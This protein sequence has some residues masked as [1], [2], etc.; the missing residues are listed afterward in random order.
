MTDEQI[1]AVITAGVRAGAISWLGYEKDADGHY[2]LPAISISDRQAA[3]AIEAEVAAPFL[4]NI[5]SLTARNTEL[6]AKVSAL[7]KVV[8]SLQDEIRLYE[9]RVGRDRDYIE[10]MRDQ[11]TQLDPTRFGAGYHK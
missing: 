5:S 8:G 9:K 4:E 2:T 6:T 10:E 7:E 1:D 11:L 3:R